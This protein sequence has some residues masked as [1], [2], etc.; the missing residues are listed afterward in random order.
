[1]SRNWRAAV[2]GQEQ[3]IPAFEQDRQKRCINDGVAANDKHG[4]VVAAQLARLDEDMSSQP[5][6]LAAQAFGRCQAEQ[7]ADVAAQDAD[8]RGALARAIGIALSFLPRSGR[9]AR[10]GGIGMMIG[11]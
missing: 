7:A 10:V 1:V 8:G 3:Q 6:N 5:G 2:R 4:S 11:R 9:V